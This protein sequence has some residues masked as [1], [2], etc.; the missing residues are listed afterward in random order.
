MGTALKI[1]DTPSQTVELRDLSQL[2]T[3]CKNVGRPGSTPS[4]FLT[5][6]GNLEAQRL[7]TCGSFLGRS[8][9]VFF[10]LNEHTKACLV[11][12]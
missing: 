5:R 10:C 1:F 6:N 9:L 2:A 3:V 8:G 4:F 7:E 11:L 12:A